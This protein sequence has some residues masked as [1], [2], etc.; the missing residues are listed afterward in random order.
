MMIAKHAKYETMKRS[1]VS[2]NNMS[3][4]TDKHK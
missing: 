3:E 1:L 2:R 4:H